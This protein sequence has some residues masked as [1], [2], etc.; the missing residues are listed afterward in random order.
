ML[1]LLISRQ[2]T[3]S[4]ALLMAGSSCGS[5][6]LDA[7]CRT[8]ANLIEIGSP[9]TIESGS[10]WKPGS[11]PPLLK[12]CLQQ[13]GRDE[14]RLGIRLQAVAE[15]YRSRLEFN[16]TWL[17]AVMPIVLF[18]LIGGGTILV[19]AMAVFWPVVEVYRSLS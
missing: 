1:N 8:E 15:F 2:V 19:Y 13:T 11:L 5:D 12:A 3:L 7:A 4:E 6:E 10:R 14:Q 16:T 18:L 9:L 17:R